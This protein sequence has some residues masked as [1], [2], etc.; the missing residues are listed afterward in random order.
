M[1]LLT[2]ADFAV[3]VGTQRSTTGGAVCI[4]GP[5][6]LFPIHVVLKRQEMTASSTP[7]ADIVAA[8]TILRVVL[9]PAPYIWEV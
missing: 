9:I 2:D 4:E 5:H 1:A 6:S 8:D 7:E 3:G